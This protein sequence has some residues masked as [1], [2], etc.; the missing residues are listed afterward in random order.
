MRENVFFFAFI[1][2]RVLLGMNSL[3]G[4]FLF[5]FN[6]LKIFL[7]FFLACSV[8]VKN[9]MLHVQHL[10]PPVADSTVF[11]VSLTLSSLTMMS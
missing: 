1:F 8:P 10:F 4:R 9:L 7:F 2:E 3:V 5:S 6:T 11:S